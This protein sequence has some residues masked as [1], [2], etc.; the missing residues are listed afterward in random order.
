MNIITKADKKR[1]RVAAIG[2]W[3]GV[4]RGHRFLID[5]LLLEAGN[6]GL[7]PAVV[8]FSDHPKRVVSPEQAPQMLSTLSDRVEALGA[9]GVVDV[10]MLTFNE[11]MRRQS[12]RKFLERL[13]KSFGV[14]TLV[15]GYNNR[16][17]HERADGLKEYQAIGKEIG[18]EIVAAP[19]YKG[20]GEESVSSSK[21]REKLY[22]GQIEDAARM[23]GRP[24]SLR[25]IVVEGKH[26]GRTIGFPT[27]NLRS[28]SGMALI[29][30]SGVYAAFV[31]TPDGVRRPAVVNIGVR[32][33][34]D[35]SDEAASPELSVE[36]HIPGFT[37]YLYDD[38][39]LLEFIHR[40][41]DERRF[42]TLD[43]LRQAISLDVSET[44]RRLAAD[45]K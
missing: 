18:L 12:A 41:R 45:I 44:L 35:N 20:I 42:E 19:E 29:P 6:R 25:G 13:K 22:S 11:R 34:V 43:D 1:R 24:Y 31:T 5:Y 21:I 3:D 39:L 23:L 38:E 30:G 8:T 10:I 37:G 9:A 33:T 28:T 26:L 27:A 40:L 16:F 14:D 36:I 2:M 32:P 15:V 17:G 7:T 4:H